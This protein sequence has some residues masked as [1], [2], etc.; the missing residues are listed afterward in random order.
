MLRQAYVSIMSLESSQQPLVQRP[1]R[2]TANVLLA[3]T[4]SAGA[5]SKHL[6]TILYVSSL[7]SSAYEI[8]MIKLILMFGC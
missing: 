7:R 4:L 8:V 3:L 1:D 2:T 5:K 6:E